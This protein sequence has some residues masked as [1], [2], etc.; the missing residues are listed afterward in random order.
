MRVR[1]RM[2]VSTMLIG[3]VIVPMMF[4]VM[5]GMVV[6]MSVV[7]QQEHADDIHQ[8][9]DHRDGNRFVVSYLSGTGWFADCLLTDASARKAATN[10]NRGN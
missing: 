5:V 8:E 1:V 10:A 2:V 6:A 9:A 4:M 3:S 7:V